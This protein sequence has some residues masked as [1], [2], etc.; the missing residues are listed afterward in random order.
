MNLIDIEFIEFNKGDLSMDFLFIN[1]H[2]LSALSGLSHIQQ[3]AYLIGIR[4]YMDR[5]TFIVGIKRKISYQ[6]LS[7]ALYVEPHKGIQSGSPSKAQMRRVVKTLERAGLVQIQSTCENLILKC[8]LVDAN[9]SV[10]NKAVTKP[11][12]Y[13][14]TV[15]HDE[16]PDASTIVA[17]N[18]QKA[19]MGEIAKAVIPHNSENYFV[20]L[21]KHFEKFWSLYPQH[22]QKNKAWNEFKKLNP[23]DE[24]FSQ[25][26]TALE[27]Q[28]QRYQQIQDA[29][30]WQPA[31][32][33]PANWLAQQCWNDELTPFTPQENNNAKHERTHGKK[34]TYDA[35]WEACKRGEDFNFGEDEYGL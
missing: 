35:Y 33:Q 26:I 29:D 30:Q 9:S 25:I 16:N 10:Q 5:K 14:V 4:P 7:E 27:A 31:W 21:G 22:Q 34:S 13:P 12:P 28:C 18:T 1:T 19:D 17:K 23:N 15:S 32:K 20:F 8:G 3:L 6:S 2:E 24:L 11:S